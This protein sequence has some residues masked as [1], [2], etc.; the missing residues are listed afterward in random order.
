[1]HVMISTGLNLPVLYFIGKWGD[2]RYY[3]ICINESKLGVEKTT[4]VLMYFI[5]ERMK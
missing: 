5:E 4:E 2:S 1:M 3:D